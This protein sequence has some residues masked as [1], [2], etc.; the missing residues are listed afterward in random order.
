M[1]AGQEYCGEDWSKL[2]K[3]YI[4]HDKEDLLRHCFSSAYIV[5]LLHDSLGI[6][7][8]DESLWLGGREMGT[9]VLLMTLWLHKLKLGAYELLTA[10][11]YSQLYSTNYISLVLK[12]SIGQRKAVQCGDFA[13]AS[14]WVCGLVVGIIRASNASIG[15]WNHFHKLNRHPKLLGRPSA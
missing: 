8:D 4:S 5:A 3:K 10:G 9:F 1:T 2:K 6:G 14:L 13:G 11:S 7:M 15:I 12:C